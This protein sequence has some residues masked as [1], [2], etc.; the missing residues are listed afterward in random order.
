[1][2]REQRGFTIVEIL[3]GLLIGG[4]LLTLAVPS[5]RDYLDNNRAI[6]ISN[7]FIAAIH[8]ARSEAIKR[9]DFVSVC[10]ASDSSFTSCGGAG[11]WQNGWIIFSDNN[12]DGVIDNVNDRIKVHDPLSDQASVV[13][14]VPVV[15]FSS[16][17]LAVEGNNGNFALEVTGC[18]GTNA[19]S[20]SISSTG[21]VSTTK[22]NCSD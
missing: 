9:G 16:Q 4:I 18:T 1:M 14:A 5:F 6:T 8:L 15:T 7:S 2:Q 13:T 10:P 11:Q 20:V 22:T 12:N 3:I 19:R 17:G 21:R